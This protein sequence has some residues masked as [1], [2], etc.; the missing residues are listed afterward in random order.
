MKKYIYLIFL[1]IFYSCTSPLANPSPET[2]DLNG[3][4][5]FRQVG[6]EQWVKASVPGVVQLDLLN[7]GLI[8]DPFY[9]KNEEE[10]WWIELENWEY[11]RDFELTETQYAH[12]RLD[13][14]FEGVDT[15]ADVWVNEVKVLSA[16]N[17]FCTWTKDFKS[18]AK[19]GKNTIKVV[20]RSPQKEKKAAYDALGYQLPAG[21][22]AAELKISPF[23]RKAPYHFGW[24]WGPRLVTMGIWR[25]VSIEAWSEAKI[26]DLYFEQK[27]VNANRA[28]ITAHVELEA[29]KE[30]EYDLVLNGEGLSMKQSIQTKKGEQTYRLDFEIE[31]PKLW[32]SKGLG[33][34]FRYDWKVELVQKGKVLDQKEE[35]IGLRKIELIQEPD[36][37]GTS[38][39]F[40]LNGVPVFMKGAN[41]IPQD[42]I[43]PR[44]K[45][46]D[47]ERVINNV[48]AAN[49]NMLRVWG[50]GVYEDD[51]F[52][53][54]C[55][56]NGIL[57]WQDFM[58]ACGMYPVNDAFLESVGKELDDNIKR[59]R[60]R[61]SIAL[62][63]GN[64]EM[65]VAWNNWGWQK[66]FG[67]SKKDSLEIITGYQKLFDELIPSKLQELNVRER[68]YVPTSPLSN[69]G[70]AENFNHKSMHYWGVWHGKEPFENYKTNVGRFMSEYGFQSFPEMTTVQAFA[71]DSSQ[72]D[73]ESEVMKHHQKSYIGNGMILEHLE[74]YFP[75]PKTFEQFTYLS[76]LTQALGIGMAIESHRKAKGHC[77]GTLYWQLNDCWPGPSWSSVDYYGRWKALHYRVR[78]L[79]KDVVVL[80][81]KDRDLLMG[82]IISD[83]QEALEGKLDLTVYDL[84][85]KVLWENS[86]NLKVESNQTW[87]FM[88]Y[89]YKKFLKKLKTKHAF[90]QS[91]FSVDGELITEHIHYFKN[92]KDLK[93]KRVEPKLS[94]EKVGD[95]YELK[96]STPTLIKNLFLTIDAENVQYSDNYFDVLPNQEK[97]IRIETT[98]SLKLGDIEMMSVNSLK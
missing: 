71:K 74:T 15:Y 32:W 42:N 69:W 6:K 7:A 97:T 51:L 44:V 47:Y 34:P 95:A 30:G 19:V 81:S 70:T 60:N 73:L 45:K 48:V 54:L 10:M 78:D 38:Y 25:P 63:C 13:L 77:M 17:M 57:V 98:K 36:E 59:L 56:Q 72:W 28:E 5:K 67:Y 65:D 96:I 8:E 86:I 4:W 76:Q 31:N 43:I 89:S 33:E 12:D 9:G 90:F 46:E 29:N 85:G 41:Y 91:K 2:I 35:K 83:K 66:Q 1:G 50:G 16:D 20:F 93:L 21:N 92:P 80:I 26:Q 3:D 40:K 18:C 87:V 84:D 23:V 58:F 27:E 61:A 88:R 22:D 53:E 82:T 79:Y 68:P 11:E 75:K 62:W 37:I 55:D 14:T 24:D 39:Y 64:N 52:Y 94:L 49:M